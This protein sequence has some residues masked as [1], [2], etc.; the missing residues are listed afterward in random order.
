MQAAGGM[1]NA[2]D[3]Q[4]GVGKGLAEKQ[5]ATRRARS[6]HHSRDERLA[7]RRS[8]L[9]STSRSVEESSCSVSVVEIGHQDA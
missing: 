9:G 2:G 6:G 5:S 3:G 1:S 8:Y 4:F 7:Q